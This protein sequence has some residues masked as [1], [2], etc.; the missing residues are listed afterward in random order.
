MA[1]L[2][3]SG[4]GHQTTVVGPD[5]RGM[6]DH[7]IG[8]WG[9]LTK[10]R[11]L[12]AEQI[13]ERDQAVELVAVLRNEKEVLFAFAEPARDFEQG[14]GGTKERLRGGLDE[15]GQLEF[16]QCETHP[17]AFLPD[18]GRATGDRGHECVAQR[19][20][21]FGDGRENF[22]PHHDDFDGRA[23]PDRGAA[24]S[25]VDQRLFAK[26]TA[27]PECGDDFA[28]EVIRARAAD[29]HF[30]L[31]DH[32]KIRGDIT[33]AENIITCFVMGV[34]DAIGDFRLDV[35][36]IAGEQHEPGPVETDLDAAR[37]RG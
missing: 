21:G 15:I 22:P 5:D 12:R 9:R 11:G 17:R 7:K 31:F 34:G 36:E 32:K 37:P 4:G 3:E 2:P 8:E 28:A 23:R 13:G 30:A 14:F 29:F 16:L 1:V 24:R 35:A 6:A 27:G 19:R 20:E 33:L 18:V 26:K 10:S 25:V